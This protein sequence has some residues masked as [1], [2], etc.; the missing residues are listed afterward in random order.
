M[1]DFGL[2]IIGERINPGFRSSAAL[3]SAK[4]LPGLQALA[5]K[6]VDAGAR[7][8]N[9][10]VGRECERDAGFMCDV[11]RAVQ[12]AVAVP[13]SFDSPDPAVQ[14]SC[15][16]IYDAERA[17]GRPVVNSLTEHRID[18]LDCA[19]VAPLRMLI[20]ASERVENGRVVQNTS[21]EQV[22][23]TAA[24]LVDS[25]RS[26]GWTA[27]DCIIDVSIG[28]MASDMEGITRRA[29]QSI[30]RSKN[31]AANAPA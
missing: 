10:N 15:L 14:R 11:I 6:Q 2:T 19:E 9:I 29:L 30:E 27:D 16:A 18:M 23:A 17:G 26:R 31:A 12:E 22:H 28:P 13:L 7:L 3:L 1:S 20:M 8:L 21:P 25:A 5:R 4:D 24:R